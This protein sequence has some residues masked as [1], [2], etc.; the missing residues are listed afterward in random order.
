MS[1][2]YGDGLASVLAEFRVPQTGRGGEAATGIRV[3]SI[4]L[5]V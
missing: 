2:K 3:K 5:R 4:A 1:I